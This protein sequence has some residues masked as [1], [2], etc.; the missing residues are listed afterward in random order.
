MLTKW[1]PCIT[2]SRYPLKKI[3]N[4]IVDLFPTNLSQPIQTYTLY[5]LCKTINQTVSHH[6]IT[7]TIGRSLSFPSDSIM[8]SLHDIP[9]ADCLITIFFGLLRTALQSLTMTILFTKNTHLQTSVNLSTLMLW[10]WRRTLQTYLKRNL[11]YW[12]LFVAVHGIVSLF[13]GVKAGSES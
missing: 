2:L 3:S 10:V 1:T 11:N 6:K 4:N 8:Q 13:F 7:K 12:V 5:N 9:L